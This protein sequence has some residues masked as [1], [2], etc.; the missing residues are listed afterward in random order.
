MRN[1]YTVKAK[2]ALSQRGQLDSKTKIR[3]RRQLPD[4]YARPLATN[5]SSALSCEVY[6]SHCSEEA[7]SRKLREFLLVAYLADAG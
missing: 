5:A 4:P 3:G 2:S 6:P 1:S 7:T